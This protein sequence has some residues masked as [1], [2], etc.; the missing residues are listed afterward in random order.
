MRRQLILS[1]AMSVLD[2]PPEF[3]PSEAEGPQDDIVMYLS[4]P[5]WSSGV[6][7]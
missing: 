4:E 1:Y 7:F 2:P 3:V 6:I 5:D